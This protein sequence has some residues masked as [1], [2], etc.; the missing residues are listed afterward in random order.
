MSYQILSTIVK[1]EVLETK[2]QITLSDGTIIIVDIPH[3]IPS[4]TLNVLNN[5]DNRV[6]SEQEKYNAKNTNLLIK[7]QL[8]R[9]INVDSTIIQTDFNR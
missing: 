3:F 6:L 1:D 2:V 8:D 9:V 7:Q 4:S 5:I